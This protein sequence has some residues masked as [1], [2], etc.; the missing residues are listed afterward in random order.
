MRQP[1]FRVYLSY[2]TCNVHVCPLS[3]PSQISPLVVWLWGAE[4]RYQQGSAQKVLWANET[5]GAIQK[6]YISRVVSC[7]NSV[8]AISSL[9]SMSFVCISWI[10]HMWG[11]NKCYWVAGL[12]ELKLS[13]DD[14]DF[15][16]SISFCKWPSYLFHHGFL[17]M[18]SSEFEFFPPE[19]LP[20]WR[21]R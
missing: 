4:L 14:Q 21:R 18:F 8:M 15:H 10:G 2:G 19:R 12:G 17:S 11:Q 7:Y 5:E 16:L 1:T 13:I 3:L 9:T 20:W 6:I